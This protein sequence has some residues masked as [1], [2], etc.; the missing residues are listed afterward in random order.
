LLPSGDDLAKLAHVRS[1]GSEDWRAVVIAHPRSIFTKNAASGRQTSAHLVSVEHC[2]QDDAKDGLVAPSPPTSPVLL[3]V[4]KSWTFASVSDDRASIDKLFEALEPGPLRLPYKEVSDDAK[5]LMAWGAVALPHLRRSGPALTSIYRGPLAPWS[6]ADDKDAPKR[7]AA[8]S[9]ELI[10]QYPALG[11]SDVS[12]AA[13]WELGRLMMLHDP[14]AARR[15]VNWK[16]HQ[17][18]QAMSQSLNDKSPNKNSVHRTDHLPLESSEAAHS[19]PY[20]WF[21]RL[22]ALEGVPFAY[23]VPDERM[24]PRGPKVEAIR[25]FEVDRR[26]IEALVCGA[27][28]VGPVSASEKGK[29]AESIL[30]KMDKMRED[31]CNKKMPARKGF[32]LRSRLVSDWPEL[33]VSGELV[34]G[35]SAFSDGDHIKRRLSGD[36][37]LHLFPAKTSK[38]HL[39]LPKET[40]HFEWPHSRDNT[41]TEWKTYLKSS[42]VAE[43]CLYKSPMITFGLE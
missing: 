23:L 43:K 21:D 39:S 29:H 36:V 1:N 10:Q 5:T 40:L 25:F 14:G 17:S 37:E 15:L 41:D 28:S 38:V 16:S 35:E 11:V 12:Y 6:G 31:L 33:R 24:L 26:W 3:V 42:A 27:F 8:R 18:Q 9:H 19:F 7:D 32:L 2:Y 34:S 30:K 22:I 4:L 20:A 13:A